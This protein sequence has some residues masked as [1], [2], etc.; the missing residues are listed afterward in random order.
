MHKFEGI[1]VYGYKQSFSTDETVWWTDVDNIRTPDG[2]Q[3]PDYIGYL[4]KI[5]DVPKPPCEHEV[6]QKIITAKGIRKTSYHCSKCGE[7]FKQPVW[8]ELGK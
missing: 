8:E 5:E 3:D 7:R 4:S 2:F 1:K 6:I